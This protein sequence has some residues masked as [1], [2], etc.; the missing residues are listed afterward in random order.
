MQLFGRYFPLG[1][2]T[3]SLA[4]DFAY[5]G[6]GFSGFATV[7]FWA[8]SA[9]IVGALIDV[10]YVHARRMSL[11][12]GVG[13]VMMIGLF[14]WSWLLRDTDTPPTGDAITL[15]VLGL[16]LALVTGWLCG[17]LPRVAGGKVSTG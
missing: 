1:L 10:V 5:L 8:L 9:G 12:H 17:E 11:W 2:L 13:N 3:A 7:S 4:F 16:S 15:S 6:T 14:A